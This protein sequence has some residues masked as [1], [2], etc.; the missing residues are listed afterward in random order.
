MD[1]QKLGGLLM[2][3]DAQVLKRIVERR[4]ADYKDAVNLYYTSKLYSKLEQEDTKIW[5]L[6]AETLY[7]L[8]DE[9]LT[10]GRITFPEEQS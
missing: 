4:K 8:L 10:T 2:I 1:K 5:H 3:L 9:E 6:S 7:A